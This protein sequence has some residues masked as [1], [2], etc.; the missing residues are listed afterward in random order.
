MKRK[1]YIGSDIGG[2]HMRTALVDESGSILKRQKTKTDISLGASH[3]A[4]KLVEECKSLIE[5]AQIYGGCVQ[6][7]GL[8]VAGKIDRFKGW[9]IFSPNLP[10]LRDYPLGPELEE[11]LGIPVIMEN[12]A[13][14]FGVGEKW[15]GAGRDIDNWIGLTLGTGVGGCLI[16]QGRL[17]N[18][19]DLG[20]VGEIGHMIVHPEGPTCACGLRGCLEAHASGSALLRG[21]GEAIATGKLS[22]GPLFDRWQA[23]NLDPDSIYH[24]AEQGD[25]L[26]QTL[27]DRMGWALGLA[28][29]S[30]FTVLGIR[31]AI[32]GGGVSASWLRFIE[33]LQRSLREHSSMLEFEKMAIRRA[34]LGD[35]AALLGAA[36]L[37]QK[38]S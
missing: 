34:V 16:L 3:V 17:W 20:F 12:D 22:A 10:E 1:I 5:Q 32:L 2:T 19:D 37:A 28:I 7:I 24:F 36:R 38:R 8:G 13:N 29:A 33:P 21:V 30:L 4:L 31:H 35:D 6:S 26:T 25:S 15:V 23:G 27:F 14:M 9:V 11:T 18:G